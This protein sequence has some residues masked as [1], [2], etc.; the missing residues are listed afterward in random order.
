[1]CVLCETQSIICVRYAVNPRQ[2]ICKVARRFRRV[3]RL[4]WRKLGGRKLRS[5]RACSFQFPVRHKGAK[6]KGWN[7]LLVPKGAREI[8]RRR[9][10]ERARPIHDETSRET[11]F[12]DANSQRDRSNFGEAP[13]P[14]TARKEIDCRRRR[15]RMQRSLFEHSDR[16]FLWFCLYTFSFQ[17][18][19]H[20]TAYMK[21]A[22]NAK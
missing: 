15:A 1:M 21:K 22:L 7:T 18:R 10:C 8:Q 9:W 16:A 14:K 5:V 3:P 17:F 11:Q 20:E 12:A 4:L 6:L 19:A 2:S 13:S